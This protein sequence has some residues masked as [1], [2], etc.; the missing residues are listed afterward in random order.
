MLNTK[1]CAAQ[2][3]PLAVLQTVVLIAALGLTQPLIALADGSLGADVL[4]STLRGDDRYP[5]VAYNG[6]AHEF[7]AVWEHDGDIYGQRYGEDGVPVNDVFSITTA[8]GVQTHPAVAYSSAADAYLVMWEDTPDSVSY[9]VH[10]R[11]V[12]ADGSLLNGVSVRDSGD[13]QYAPDV[14]SDGTSFLVVWQE[15]VNGSLW[16]YAQRVTG[17]GQAGSMC[18]VAS[19]PDA[20]YTQPALAYNATAGEY[21]IVFTYGSG[22]TAAIH[23]QRLPP[24]LSSLGDVYTIAAQPDA[25]APQVASSLVGSWVVVWHDRRVSGDSNIYGRV[26]LAGA[27]ASFGGGSFAI[28][29]QTAGQYNP[30]IASLP[31]TGHFLVAWED[32]RMASSTWRDIYGQVLEEDASLHGANFVI[33]QANGNQNLPVIAAGR[34][35]DVFL[36]AWQD[37]RVSAPDIYGQRLSSSGA[38]L[39]YEF[40]ISAQPGIQDGVAVAYNRDTKQYMAVWQHQGDIYGQLLENTGQPAD[41][42]W[43]I[44]DDGHTHSHPAVGSEDDGFWT[45][46]WRDNSSNFLE[47]AVVY[48][49]GGVVTRASV[50]NSTG[51]DYPRLVFGAADDKYMIVWQAN[52]DIFAT[53]ASSSGLPSNV[54]LDVCDVANE[55]SFPD[56]AYDGGN[57]QFLV[58]WQDDRASNSRIYGRPILSAMAMAP[59]VPIAGHLDST[60][61]ARPAITFNPTAGSGGEYLVV[62]QKEVGSKLYNVAGQRLNASGARTGGEIAIRN[63]PA[64]QNHLMPGAVYVSSVDRYY[65]LW[66]EDRGAPNGYDLYARWLDA[67]GNLVTLTLP[68]FGYAADQEHPRLA[69][70]ADHDRGLAAWD[71]DRRVAGDVYAR[72]GVTDT[73]PPQAILTSI[74]LAGPAG[75]NFVLD[76]HHSSDNATPAGALLARWDWTSNGSWDTPWSLVKVVTRTIGAS[77]TYTVSVQV[78]DLMGY[79]D[80]DHHAVLVLPASSNTPP[81]ATLTIDPGTA[82]AGAAFNFDASGSTDAETAAEDLE[83]CWDWSAEADGD[84]DTSWSTTKTAQHTYNEAGLHTVR[85]EVKDEDEFTNGAEGALTVVAGAVTQ[86]ALTPEIAYVEAGRQAQFHASGSDAYGNAMSNPSVAWSL[87]DPAA[88][89]IDSQGLFTA[90]TAR[91]SY[92][93][94][95]TASAGDVHAHASVVVVF[96][97]GVYLP[98]LVR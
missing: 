55:Q 50:P 48:P 58:V 82:A 6:H 39:W 95:V 17:Q 35:S 31:G 40:A 14:A 7:L 3:H 36:V 45:M 69:Y 51:G 44:E 61:R 78:M 85:V 66:S 12:D 4:L 73:E 94:T 96:P 19:S 23:A 76:A 32:A 9:R 33:N 49:N 86:L 93:D 87:A 77:G 11:R 68:F 84:C 67:A 83:V 80:V 62:Y 34:A 60:S 75:T 43:V 20:P 28:S 71:D 18:L 64:G 72:S 74:P 57:H 27:D 22:S 21:L 38:P 97:Y 63:D 37:E 79:T 65:T 92:T 24:S 30:A 13:N 70:D 46:V 59:E 1:T 41:E 81:T 88:G 89:S 26:V 98:M 8:A 25:G 10:G 47:A 42:P 52:G 56:L 5:A 29:N 91:G 53:S 2:L 15:D 54:T 90:G 16:I